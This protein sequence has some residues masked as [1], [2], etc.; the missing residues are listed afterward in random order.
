MS[1]IKSHLHKPRIF[2]SQV[3]GTSEIDIKPRNRTV[4]SREYLTPDEVARLCEAA[5][6][7]GRHGS[8][9]WLIIL[10]MYRHALRAGELV[11]LHWDQF[12]LDASKLHVNRLKNGDPSVHYLEGDELRAF[13]KLRR[14]YSDSDFVFCT[15]R[16]G[17]LSTRTV[18]AIVARAGREAG[19][20]FPVHP[21]MLRHAKG[22]QLASRA[23][24]T[25]AIQAYMGHKNIQ[26]TVLYTKLD[27]RRFKG[28]GRD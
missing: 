7:I 11:D 16:G 22:Y 17:P 23:E 10:T 27:P 24:D 6:D 4:R 14:Q 19:I 2:R 28:F 21:H 20:Q 3:K 1:S 25:R 13:R 5:Q 9:D 8:R 18:H 26:H 12:H 15:E